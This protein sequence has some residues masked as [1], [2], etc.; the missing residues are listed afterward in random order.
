MTTKSNNVIALSTR[1]ASSGFEAGQAG[2]RL[3][4]IPTS[5]LAINNAIRTYG[6]NAIA[7]SRFLCVNDPYMV[8]AKE[9]FI[10]ALVGDGIKPSF[11]TDDP[12]IKKELQ[13]LFLEWTDESDA[14]KTTDFYGQQNVAAAEMFEAG[15]CFVRLRP[16]YLTDG[17]SVP[18]QLQL[19]PAEMLP[20]YHNVQ[21][22]SGRRIEMGIQFDAIGRREGYWFFR[23]HP[24]EMQFANVPADLLHFVP[25]EEVLH[26][27]KPIRAGQIR[28]VPHT[29]AGILAVALMN[30]Y[31]DAELERKRT[32]ALFTAFITRDPSE[33]PGDNPLGG[34]PSTTDAT[35]GQ[36]TSGMEPG[37]TVELNAG[38]SVEFAEPADVGGNYEAFQYRNLL[39]AAA[40]VGV[41]YMNM[42]GDLRQAN[43][44]S[45]RGGQI[46]FKRRI[47]MLQNMVFIFQFCRPIKEAWLKAALLS[48]AF[49][50]F[51]ATDYLA[52][53]R[54]FGK[55]VRWIP[56]KWE[57]IDPLKDLSAEKLAVDSGFKPRSDVI[58][59]MG[60]DAEEVDEQIARDQERADELGLSFVQS[61]TGI[62]VS[63]NTEFESKT[64]LDPNPN[65]GN[66]P[67]NSPTP[68]G[69]R[70][71]QKAR[72][73]ASKSLR[74]NW[75][76]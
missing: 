46:V 34:T 58:E 42:T 40:G 1:V 30:L 18:L 63:P 25:A 47:S 13:E 56:P 51:S 15:E 27:F 21:L 72:R 8:Q 55:R 74:Y 41:P 10:A 66:Y 26:L 3:R 71:K 60:Y 39:R 7:R 65:G 28:G 53:P 11:I 52:D 73:T 70:Q 6:K 48:K 20:T 54:N 75:D 23:S 4:A 31:D 37:A 12:E 35:T 57:W 24:G 59:A 38:Q 68:K 33:N 45:Q 50:K 76:R 19:L 9:E 69:P 17:L 32:A 49:K 5:A 29:L 2:R 43:Y 64:S 36:V 22:G 61:S 14:D 16:R 44:G 62:V 67:E